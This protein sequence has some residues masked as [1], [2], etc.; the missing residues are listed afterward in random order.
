M[1]EGGEA[2]IF[3][4]P[5]PVCAGVP[6]HGV[7]PSDLVCIDQHDEV[8]TAHDPGPSRKGS[9]GFGG[10]LPAE[11]AFNGFVIDHDPV[12]GGLFQD[13]YE[14]VS[15]HGDPG[16]IEGFVQTHGEPIT[17][18]AFSFA[19][20]SRDQDQFI[21][22]VS[23]FP[24]DR[25]TPHGKSAIYNFC[26]VQCVFHN[27][28]PESEIMGQVRLRIPQLYQGICRIVF[29]HGAD[30]VAI[31]RNPYLPYNQEYGIRSLI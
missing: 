3:D 28:V 11:E 30:S 6:H 18:G 9:V 19:G 21:H 23:D 8:S 2:V 1:I 10:V 15:L 25:L 26:L 4:V 27:L 22:V 29:K 13:F 24:A 16:V 12:A 7:H 17:E 20:G 31:L 14:G 5:N